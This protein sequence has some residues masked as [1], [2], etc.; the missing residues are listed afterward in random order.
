M[1]KKTIETGLKP[2]V[3][4]QAIGS[5]LQVKGWDRRE[6]LAKSSSDNDLILEEDDISRRHL[7]IEVKTDHIVL[8]DLKSTNGVFVR[9]RRI[10]VAILRACSSRAGPPAISG[11]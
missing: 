8:R 6:V 9:G 2:E 1:A 7:Q 5:D 4:I 11:R 3:N 10:S